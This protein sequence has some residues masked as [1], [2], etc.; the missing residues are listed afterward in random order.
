LIIFGYKFIIY[1]LL[2]SYPFFNENITELLTTQVIKTKLI[3]I[4]TK[5]F[6]TDNDKS[7]VGHSVCNQG[8][9]WRTNLVHK[10]FCSILKKGAVEQLNKELRVYHSKG[11]AFNNVSQAELDQIAENLRTAPM[12][13]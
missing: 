2:S 9:D 1:F 6:P 8:F 12:N 4:W 13:L 10:T 5:N 3:S 7:F 11:T